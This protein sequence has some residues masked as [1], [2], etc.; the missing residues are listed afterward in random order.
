MAG[1]ERSTPIFLVAGAGHCQR[2]TS[3]TMGADGIKSSSTR[4]RCFLFSADDR[5]MA[6]LSAALDVSR[7]ENLGILLPELP[8]AVEPFHRTR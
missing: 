5:L 2:T 4:N 7:A 6:I 3:V 8:H 1:A